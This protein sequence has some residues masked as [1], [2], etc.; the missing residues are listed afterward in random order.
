MRKIS[1]CLPPRVCVWVRS[2]LHANRDP[3]MQSAYLYVT[4]TETSNGARGKYWHMKSRLLLIIFVAPRIYYNSISHSQMY[5]SRMNSEH[6][7]IISLNT[8]VI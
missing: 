5:E 3:K 7:T 1:F 2:L 4:A 8:G 6:F